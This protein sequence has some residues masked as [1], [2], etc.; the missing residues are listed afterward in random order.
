M[1]ELKLQNPDVA[2]KLM[3]AARALKAPRKAL[4]EFGG[5]WQ[6]ET[7]QSM[8]NKPPGEAAA[9]GEPPAIHT[10]EYVHAIIYDV[11]AAGQELKLGSSH[12]AARVLNEGGTINAR[13]RRF[14]AIPIAAESY[15]KRPRDFRG[16]TIIARFRRGGQTKLLL[17]RRGAMRNESGRYTGERGTLP[18]FVLQPHARIRKHPHILLRASDEE[19]LGGAIERQLDR[20]LGLK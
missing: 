14:L 3:Q 4:G 7:K 6:R 10:S 16:L 9:E 15:G 18:L 20:E 13:H 12:V 17:G 19:Y 1:I 11:D 8:G 2:K 5:H